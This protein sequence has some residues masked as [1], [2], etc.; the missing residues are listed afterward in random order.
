VQALQL[1]C[2][3]LARKKRMRYRKFFVAVQTTRAQARGGSAAPPGSSTVTRP[4]RP[5]L[6]SGTHKVGEKLQHTLPAR[7][8]VLA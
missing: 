5:G 2:G 4:S 3:P 1:S 6:T 7:A 8:V